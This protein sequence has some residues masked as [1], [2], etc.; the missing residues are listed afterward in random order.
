MSGPEELRALVEEMR[1]LAKRHVNLVKTGAAYAAGELRGA[2]TSTF[3]IYI[4]HFR[5]IG[6]EIEA[7]LTRVESSLASPAGMEGWM[8]IE[9]APKDGTWVLLYSPDAVEPQVFQG[10]FIE[11]EGDPDPAEWYVGDLDQP[12]VL[13][14]DPTHW[15]PLP[16]APRGEAE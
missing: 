1:A 5:E 12:V 7:V 13:D 6:K 15:R 8:P 3:E 9:T 4:G 11:F 2:P 14:A 16:A 10:R